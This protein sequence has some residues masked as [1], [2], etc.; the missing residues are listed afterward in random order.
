MYM[1]YV[2]ERRKSK[3][4]L[5]SNQQKGLIPIR[6][7]KQLLLLLSFDLIGKVVWKLGEKEKRKKGGG[8]ESGKLE[9]HSL[10][11]NETKSFTSYAE[12]KW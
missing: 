5:I 4:Y 6:A 12:L 7:F 1:T 11:H 3:K 2:G 9:F 8:G 10:S